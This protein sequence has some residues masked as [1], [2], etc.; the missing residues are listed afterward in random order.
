[1]STLAERMGI[2]SPVNHITL[3]SEERSS[4]M[5][6]S[7]S[8]KNFTIREIICKGCGRMIFA[9]VSEGIYQADVVFP[10]KVICADGRA[11]HNFMHREDGEDAGTVCKGRAVTEAEARKFLEMY[12]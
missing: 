7:D 10:I 9:L 8:W 3:D 12:K 6:K 1:M 11:V 5:T 2:K 4:W